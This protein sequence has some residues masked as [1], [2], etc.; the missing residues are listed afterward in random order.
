MK[1]ELMFDLPL[2]DE[3]DIRNMVL[4]VIYSQNEYFVK[5]SVVL[6]LCNELLPAQFKNVGQIPLV[7]GSLGYV[8]KPN[9][10]LI[11]ELVDIYIKDGISTGNIKSLSDKTGF[12]VY[13]IIG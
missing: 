4:R 10:T 6:Q 9:E 7:A 12:M 2:L 5:Q 8:I 11:S 3:A 1:I 13:Q